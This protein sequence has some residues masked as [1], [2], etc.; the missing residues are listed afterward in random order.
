VNQW[1]S[2]ATVTRLQVQNGV[3]TAREVFVTLSVSGTPP[4]NG[5]GIAF[6]SAGNF[7]ALAGALYKVT[8]SKAI[9]VI[10]TTAAPTSGMEFGCGTISCSDLF[11]ATS[12]GVSKMTVMDPGMNVPWHRH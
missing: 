5:D 11:F 6:D 10:P 3:E 8:P 9:T 2:P 7:Y 1:I 4:G 12:A